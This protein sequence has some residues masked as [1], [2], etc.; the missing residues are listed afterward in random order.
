MQRESGTIFLGIIMD[1]LLIIKLCCTFCAFRLF[2]FYLVFGKGVVVSHE[3][4]T[5]V[6]HEI[7]ERSYKKKRREESE[8]K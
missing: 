2:P 8:T 1:L 5:T 3:Y 4:R 7:N 6:L